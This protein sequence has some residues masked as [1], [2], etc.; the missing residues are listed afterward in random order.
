M[1]LQV[2]VDAGAELDAAAA[3]Y[4]REREGLGEEL[5]EEVGRAFAVILA[6][7]T[8]WRFVRR[9][10]GMRRLVL[11]RFPYAIFY[12]ASE[13]WVRVFAIAHQKRRPGYW[14]KRGFK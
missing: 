13:K 5:V 11:S 3:W 6:A 9:S 10:T 1:K 12:A 4:E 14:Q 7:P 2:H 8:T